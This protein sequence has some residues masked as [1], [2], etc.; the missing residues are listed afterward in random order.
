M[1]EALG[2]TSVQCTASDLVGNTATASFAV[3]VTAAPSTEL[4]GRVFGSGHIVDAAKRHHHFTFRVAQ[5]GSREFGRLEYWVSEAKACSQNDHGYGRD[6]TR[7]GHDDREYGRGAGRRPGHFEATMVSSVQLSNDPGFQPG[8]RTKPRAD[9]VTFVGMGRWNG[10]PGYR[11]EA[12]ATDQGEPGRGR[13][14]F[15]LVV[16]DA[17]GRIVANVNGTL[18]GGNIQS[19]RLR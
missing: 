13:D 1:G 7:D 4:D 18:D 16:R 17:A 10:Q 9:S 12:S 11:F 19:T 5:N 3:T 15:A 2:A 8:R 6:A 14:T